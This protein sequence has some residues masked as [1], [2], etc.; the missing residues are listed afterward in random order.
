VSNEAFHYK[1]W[2]VEVLHDGAGW[3][4]LV[5]WPISPLH[6]A[7]VPEGPDRH[8]VMEKAKTLID[9]LL[10]APGRP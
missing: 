1:G 8:L 6:E 3:K 2:R 4:A 10:E 9:E 5:Y 7:E